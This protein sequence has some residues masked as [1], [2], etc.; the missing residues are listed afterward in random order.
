MKNI[1]FNLIEKYFF[2]FVTGLNLI[3]ILSGKFFPTVDGAAHLYNSQLI[4]SLLF[5][6][7]SLLSAF[8]NFNQEPVP[9]WTGHVIL[10]FFNLF[11]PAFIAEKVLLLFYM[12]GLPLSFRALIK[13]ISA[14]NTLFSYLIFPFTYSFFLFS[15]FYNFSIGLVFILITLNY[16][17]KQEENLSSLKRILQLF[18]LLSLAYFS[19]IFAFGIILLLIAL[20]I[21][22][23][24]AIQII[25]NSNQTKEILLVSFKK[26]GALLLSSFIPLLLFSFYFYSRPSLGSNTFVNHTELINWLKNIRP[27][28]ALNFG[29]EEVYTKKIFYIIASI[30]VIAL[31]NRINEIQL[32]AKFSLGAILAIIKKTIRVSDVWLGGAIVILIFYFKLP[33]SDGAA[34]FL[35]MRLGLLFFL[36]LMIWLSTQNFPKWFSLLTIGVALYYHFKLNIYYNTAAKDLNKVAI[37]CNNASEYILPNSIVFPL[38]YSDNWLHEH[39]SNYLGIDK[40]M[41]ILENY[42]CGP[43]YFPLN[44]NEKSIPNVLL[45]NIPSKQFS[46]FHWKNN[47]QNHPLP[48]DYIFVFGNLDEKTDSCDQVIKQILSEQYILKY[49]SNSCKLYQIKNK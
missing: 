5:D 20:N 46:C 17:I 45:G 10:S 42:E 23:K 12:I 35:S 49:N 1:K 41:V 26:S 27:I 39:F 47:I 8:F 2:L 4:N 9:N 18:L 44:W 36:V 21:S 24:A 40:P 37:E 22:I 29:M 14:H 34:G 25:E 28:I 32:H 16:W 48:I 31:Y 13:T 6:T 11:F 3:P 30:C 15:G 7:D 43:G 19:H 38:N 33:D